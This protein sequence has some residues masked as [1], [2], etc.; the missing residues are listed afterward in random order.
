MFIIYGC[1][2]IWIF[3]PLLVLG[4]RWLMGIKLQVAS[5]SVVGAV[6][7][8]ISFFYLPWLDLSPIKG[9]LLKDLLDFVPD[10]V[11]QVLAWKGL[12]SAAQGM[13]RVASMVGL[14]ELSGWETLLL[15][16]PH[17]LVL[18]LLGIVGGIAI[19][20]AILTA[21]PMRHVAVGYALAVCSAVLLLSIIYFL[22]EIEGLGEHAFPSLLA[23][24]VPLLQVEI[25]WFGPLVMMS[26]LLLM[27][28]GGLMQTQ[29]S[30]LGNAVPS[31]SGDGYGDINL[32]EKKWYG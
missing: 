29:Q 5:I 8:N 31:H 3:V 13:G 17:P 19:V 32:S 2:F 27:L 23:V 16:S 24:A 4:I 11:G 7:V 18:V 26:G 1:V 25:I 9:V 12:D 14:F 28:V 6:G 10:V 20:L 15:T 22:P 30:E 21:W